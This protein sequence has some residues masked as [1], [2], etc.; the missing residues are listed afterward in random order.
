MVVFNIQNRTNV[1]VDVGKGYHAFG[2]AGNQ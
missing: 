1:G 2:E